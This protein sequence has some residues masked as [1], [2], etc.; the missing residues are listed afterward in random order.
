LID[1][2]DAWLENTFEGGRHSRS[3]ELVRELEAETDGRGDVS[4]ALDQVA[5]T[6]DDMASN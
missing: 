1:I 5:S 2:V 4:S 3:L 6:I